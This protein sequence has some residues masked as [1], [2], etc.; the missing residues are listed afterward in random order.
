MIIRLTVFL[1]LLVA[2]LAALNLYSPFLLKL[3][4]LL[5]IGLPTLSLF[6]LWHERQTD[7][8]AKVINTSLA[9]V[10]LA[11]FVFNIA[12]LVEQKNTI[13]NAA[14]E[15]LQKVGRHIITGYRDFAEIQ[16]LVKKGGVGGVF[17]TRRNV[18]GKTIDEIQQDIAHLQA[19]QRNAGRPPLWIA[20][21][22]E[23]GIVAHLSP[24]LSELPPLST[25]VQ[26][27]CLDAK[28]VTT[29]AEIQG[30][31][32][33]E[34][35]VN[36]NLAPIADL[37]NV[38]PAFDRHS[39]IAQRALSNE[40]ALVT[41]AARLYAMTLENVGITPTLKHFPGLG[42][43]DSDT[44]FFSARLMQSTQELERTDWLPF[45]QVLATSDA[46]MM[47]GH[48]IVHVRDPEYPASYSSLIIQ[49]LIRRE[50]QHDGILISDD[51]SMAPVYYSQ[52]GIGNASVQALNA[53]LDLVL[54]AYDETQYYP[55][56]AALLQ[57]DAQGILD[58]RVLQQ[59]EARLTRHWQTMPRIAVPL[60]SPLDC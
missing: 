35:G 58:T 19:I 29:Y 60:T 21:D 8:L 51:F 32:L 27:T 46:A 33:A 42:R 9:M 48:V 20:A 36:M 12:L 24:P 28:G 16:A 18:R 50:W 22:Q 34:L 37:R 25:L 45:R 13:H 39:L 44:H 4:L 43:A 55:V 3:R 40:P 15:K 7:S 17:I 41:E 14:P 10:V 54:L 57:A 31:E 47:L 56:M 59:S 53:G 26:E 1:T 6:V 23:G 49:G 52:I 38:Q 11:V 2:L 30:R 5:I